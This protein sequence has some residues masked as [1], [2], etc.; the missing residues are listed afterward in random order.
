MLLASSIYARDERVAPGNSYGLAKITAEQAFLSYDAIDLVIL[1][2]PPVYGPGGRGG[3]YGLAKCVYKGIPL[4]LA[5]ARSLRNYISRRNLISLILTMVQSRDAQWRGEVDCRAVGWF[6]C[7]HE[8]F[9]YADVKSHAR[10]KPAFPGADRF[11]DFC[12]AD[13]RKG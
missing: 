7:Q 11:A 3:C 4:P 1:R 10:E 6:L 13:R 2:P 5:R 8:R 9:G 12:W